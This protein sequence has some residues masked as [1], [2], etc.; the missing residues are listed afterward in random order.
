M[1]F[2]QVYGWALFTKNVQVH[3][4]IAAEESLKKVFL[5]GHRFQ[6]AWHSQQNRDTAAWTDL[7]DS[8]CEYQICAHCRPGAA[9]RTFLSLNAVANDE[10]M[11]CAATGFGFHILGERPV[12]NAM[13]MRNIGLREDRSVR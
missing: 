7:L 10:I 13:T 8:E 3:S 2:P 1:P 4:V 9:D 6:I 12:L 11:P 5:N